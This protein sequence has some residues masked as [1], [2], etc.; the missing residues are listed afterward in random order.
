[1]QIV[2]GNGRTFVSND[3]QKFLQN[4]GISQK[5][6]APYNP[7]TNGLAER[8][9]QPLKKSLHTIDTQKTNLYVALQR[10]LM[11]YRITPHCT[12]GISPAE[13]MFN[14]KI[15]CTLD[16]MRP[17]NN[18]SVEYYNNKSVL[19]F[20]KGK[21]VSCRNYQRGDKWIFGRIL[22]RIGKLHYIVKLDDGRTWKRHTNQIRLIGEFTPSRLSSEDKN[23]GKYIDY[24]TDIEPQQ[25]MNPLNMDRAEEPPEPLNGETGVRRSQRIR[26]PPARYGDFRVH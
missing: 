6:T 8:F 16:I 19:N 4:N 12:T 9:I 2:S 24:A 1:M 13:L 20:K 11:Q 23:V 26:A 15:R 5:L 7:A 14:R 17:K 25:A 3:F 10:I 18:E 22:K 21:R